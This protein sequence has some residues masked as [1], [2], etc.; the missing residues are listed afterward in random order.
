MSLSAVSPSAP[1][2]RAPTRQE[3]RQSLRE[4]SPLILFVLLYS[5]APWIVANRVVLPAAP[6]HDI[7]VS[8]FAFAVVSAIALFTTFA[9]WYLYHARVLK[10]PNFKAEAARRLKHDFLRRERLMLAL[11]VMLL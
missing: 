3:L 1:G 2:T 5:L 8:Y 7:I 4:N 10:V 11:P 6:Y 9:L